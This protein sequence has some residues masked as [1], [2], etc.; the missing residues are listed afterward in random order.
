MDLN[1]AIVEDEAYIR[2]ELRKILLRWEQRAVRQ[3]DI[4][5]RD[6]VTS[7]EFLKSTEKFDLVFMDIELEQKES[8]LRKSK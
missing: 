4:V 3:Y 5:T 1:I 7:E 8:G 2:E 6:F